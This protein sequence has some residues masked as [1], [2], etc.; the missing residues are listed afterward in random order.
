MSYEIQPSCILQET[1]ANSDGYDNWINQ[2]V[3]AYSGY[4]RFTDR[5]N[6]IMKNSMNS[7]KK[8]ERI[9][10]DLRISTRIKLS[11]LW[12]VVMLCYIEGDFTS[13]FPPGGYIQQ[14]L[15]GKMG[16]FP[17]TQLTLLAGSVFISIPCVMVFLSLILKPK[18]CRNVNIILALCYTIIN[19]IS[20]FTT[21]WAYFIF[22]GIVES[23]FTLL[24]VWYAWKWPNEKI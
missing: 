1:V 6:Y 13:F 18:A 15:A 9:L 7:P 22:F 14:S 16:P 3:Y 21:A 4:V 19:A 10:E 12:V 2:K 17:T 23:V 20:S 5:K 8:I 24:I 11:A